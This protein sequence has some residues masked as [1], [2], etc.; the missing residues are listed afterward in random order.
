MK[1]EKQPK[2]DLWCKKCKCY[3][4]NVVEDGNAIIRRSW[5]GECYQGQ[6]FTFEGGTGNGSFY[7]AE[8]DTKLIE[9]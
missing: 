7:C 4:D 5:D 8:C 6:D 9:K 2:K 1:K 3:P